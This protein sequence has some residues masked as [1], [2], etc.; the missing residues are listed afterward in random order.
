MKNINVRDL[1][2]LA[3]FADIGFVSKRL[4]APFANVFTDFLRV[5]GGIGTAFSLMFLVIGAYLIRRKGAATAMSLVQCILAMSLGMVGAM[6]SLSPFGYLM[7]GIIIDA[8]IAFCGKHS[9]GMT[10]SVTSA[11]AA[12]SLAA[13][14]TANFIVFRLCGAVLALYLLIALISGGLCGLLA[15]VIYKRIRPLYRDEKTAAD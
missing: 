5:P 3:F 8:V 15:T 1:I 2:L 4:I 14:L 6:G 9:T 11:N 10:V 12:G 13:A 7:P